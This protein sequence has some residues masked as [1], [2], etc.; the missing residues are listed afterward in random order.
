MLS[1][2]PAD[3][4]AQASIIVGTLVPNVGNTANG[5]VLA[6]QDIAKTGFT[7]PALG[8]APRFG[9]AWDVKGNQRL[10]VRGA[11]GL[12]FDRP[13]VNSIYGT[14]SNP[15]KS[16]NVTVRYGNLQ[17]ISTAGLTTV[18]PPAITVFTYENDLP[19]SFQWNLGVQAA[20]PFTSAVD[21][22]YTGQHSY[23]TQNTVNLNSID[24]GAAFVD[25]DEEPS[26][27]RMHDGMVETKYP[28]VNRVS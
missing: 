3:S 6:G 22:S 2:R 16:Q 4:S 9:G 17:D 10:V 23:N 19:T 5:L 13:P 1:P 12:F 26:R 28:I 25:D 24:L 14:T 11:T 15:P 21:V 20:L 18:A 7:Y 8:Y 27:H